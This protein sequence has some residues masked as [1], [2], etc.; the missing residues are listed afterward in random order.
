MNSKN[1]S[2]Q[3][4]TFYKFVKINDRARL[5]E[6]LESCCSE[7]GI[8]GSILLANEGIN[9]TVSSSKTNLNKFVNYLSEDN[10]FKNIEF[11]YSL[12]SKMPFYRMKVRL[13]DQI[14][15]MGNS[16]VD[17]SQKVGQ[18]V[19]SQDWNN[20]ISDPKTLLIDSRNFYEVS[21]GTFISSINPN[22]KTFREFPLKLD[23]IVK[24]MD[25]EKKYKKIA[26]FCTGGIRCEKAT[27]YLVNKGIK[28]VY[29]L[30]GG[31]LKYFE[32]TPSE[33]S[34]WNGE[35]FVFDNRVSVNHKLMQG[36]YQMCF[37]C[38]MPLQEKDK[39]NDSYIEGVSCPYCINLKTNQNRKRYIARQKQILLAKSRGEK[40]IAKIKNN[41]KKVL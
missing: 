17:P 24:S 30:R 41:V 9:G 38:R 25:K 33:K 40:H 26:M 1:S 4:V 15:T 3:V 19:G 13:K 21:I 8:R 28:E 16:E 36:K 35:C 32:E 18:Y 27:S 22:I 37:A 20:L 6:N 29:H 39:T 7:L 10:R 11:K 23:E 34:L 5:K 14:I 2:I 31:I 12:S